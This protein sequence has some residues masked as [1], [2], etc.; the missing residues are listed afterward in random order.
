MVRQIEGWLD[1]PPMLQ[2]L[3]IEASQTGPRAY[4][5]ASQTGP[6]DE[7]ARTKIYLAYQILGKFENHFRT[8]METGKLAEKQLLDLRKK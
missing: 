5:R 1:Q 8:I 7:L 2:P 6:N 4:V 3:S